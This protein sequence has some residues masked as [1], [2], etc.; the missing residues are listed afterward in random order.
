MRITLEHPVVVTGTWD[1]GTIRHDLVRTAGEF[2]IAEYAGADAPVTFR[3]GNGRD[4][5]YRTIE[6]RHYR[7]A[8]DL[9]ECATI[10]DSASRLLLIRDEFG[11]DPIS[12]LLAD[13]AARIKRDFDA[14]AGIQNRNQRFLTREEKIGHTQ[15]SV[16]CMK[17]PKLR[18]WRWLSSNTAVEVE[19]WRAAAAD[20]LSN[21]VLIDGIPH[22]RVA[23]PRIGLHFI[24]GPLIETAPLYTRQVHRHDPDLDGLHDMGENALMFGYQYFGLGEIEDMYAFASELGWEAERQF[25]GLEIIDDSALSVDHLKMETVRHARIAVH[26]VTRA[27]ASKLPKHEIRDWE[28]DVGP[29]VSELGRCLVTLRGSI[30]E[31]Q[32][33][34]GDTESVSA[35]LDNLLEALENLPDAPKAAATDRGFTIIDQMNALRLRQDAAPISLSAMKFGF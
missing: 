16:D 7:P 12:R 6:G 4:L 21:L 18:N 29:V 30:L 2:E 15:D 26:R 14:S 8:P 32:Q 35:G 27:L 17:A 31:W 34:Q 11:V 9:E 5:E 1:A 25:N 10:Q 3:I 13:E 23:E 19:R 20:I 33:H 22:R 24:S 28:M